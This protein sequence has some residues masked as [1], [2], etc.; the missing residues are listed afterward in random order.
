MKN[1][2]FSIICG[3]LV[4]MLGVSFYLIS[5]SIPILN[6]SELQAN[7]VLVIG[8]I[9]SAILGTYIFY[10]KAQMKP[11]T[12]ALTFMGVAALLDALFT[13]PVFV[14]PSGGS[15]ASFFSNPMFY[16]ILVEFYFLVFYFGN[17]LIK[18]TQP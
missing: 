5:F 10:Q 9:P 4:W 17:F 8:V 16:I 13:V 18:K 12:L 14:I 7:L 2:L 6:N 1:R 15:Y 11:S 3:I